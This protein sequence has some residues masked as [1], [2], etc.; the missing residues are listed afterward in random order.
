MN[1]KNTIV[2]DVKDA[3]RNKDK[4]KLSI[5]RMIQAAFK[6]KEI[7]DRVEINDDIAF[8]ILDKMAKQHR[9][10][11]EQFSKVNR[12]DL[13]E[14]EQY[15]LDVIE[16]YLPEK[17]STVEIKEMIDIAISKTGAESIRDMKKIIGI[18]KP[19]LHGRADLGLVSK[20]IKEKLI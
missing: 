12:N 20:L 8:A 4:N 17:L 13:V 18:L 6:Q 14:K 9:D 3:M 10:S 19:E 15:E 11:I 1:I 5:L 2:E 7:D 16:Q